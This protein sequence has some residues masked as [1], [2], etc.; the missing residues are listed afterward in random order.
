V[1]E[2]VLE[3]EK[4][5]KRPPENFAQ[6]KSI[7]VSHKRKT[8]PLDKLKLNVRKPETK[9]QPTNTT[10]NPLFAKQQ[11]NVP[12]LP[13]LEKKAVPVVPQPGHQQEMQEYSQNV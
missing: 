9:N 13:F 8:N 10:M 2:V 11:G 5:T 12:K 6:Y 1:E 3:L 4:I 7:S